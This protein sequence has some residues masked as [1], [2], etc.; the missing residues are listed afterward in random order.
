MGAKKSENIC[1]I[2]EKDEFYSTVTSFTPSHTTQVASPFSSERL[3]T[4]K[5][6]E[7]EKKPQN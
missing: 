5:Q 4:I 2:T 3:N 6:V 7:K 1:Y